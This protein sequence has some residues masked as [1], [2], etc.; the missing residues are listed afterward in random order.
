MTEF[1]R[2]VK[3]KTDIFPTTHGPDGARVEVL[4]ATMPLKE[5]LLKLVD[6]GVPALPVMHPEVG[7]KFR[8]VEMEF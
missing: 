3:C 7:T 1:L 8:F 5:A 6:M 4:P 2:S